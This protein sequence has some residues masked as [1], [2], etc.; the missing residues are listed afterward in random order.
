MEEHVKWKVS[1]ELLQDFKAVHGDDWQ[2]QMLLIQQAQEKMAK[3]KVLTDECAAGII[4]GLQA[5]AE[6]YPTQGFLDRYIIVHNPLYEN[7]ESEGQYPN[8][9]IDTELIN[10]VV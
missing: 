1:A 2:R 5:I 8:I 6:G 9:I 3:N 4:R 10:S 7:G